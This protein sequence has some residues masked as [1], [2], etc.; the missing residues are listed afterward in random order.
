MTNEGWAIWRRQEALRLQFA[1]LRAKVAWLMKDHP[2]D[3][4]EVPSI[5]DVPAE[6]AISG[7][8]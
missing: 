4:E 5:P 8:P 6:Q 3:H 2:H 1:V 7:G